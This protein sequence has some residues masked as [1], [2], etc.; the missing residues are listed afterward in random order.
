MFVVAFEGINRSGKST[1]LRLAVQALSRMGFSVQAVK[2]PTWDTPVGELLSR[3]FRGSA[4]L[5]PLALQYLLEANKVEW[6]PVFST[7]AQNGTDFL[8]LDRYRLSGLVY[9]LARGLSADQVASLQAPLIQPSLTL[10]YDVDVQA[11]L[12]RMQNATERDEQ[13]PLFL[14]RV[15]DLYCQTAVSDPHAHVIDAHGAIDEVHRTTMGVIL[16]EYWAQSGEAG[17]LS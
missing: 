15:R 9:G 5:D 11:A 1:Q 14:Q 4:N 7:W 16:S 8:L 3:Y 12:A 10:V 17:V 13:D 2:F 6:L